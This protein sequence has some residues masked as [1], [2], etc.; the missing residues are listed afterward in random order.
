M[1]QV[2]VRPEPEELALMIEQLRKEHSE[3]EQRLET[4]NRSVRLTPSEEQE[5]RQIKR[6]KLSKKDRIQQLTR[7][8]ASS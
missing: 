1:Q 6:A 7:E 8:Q 2:D 4:L 3:L 5:V